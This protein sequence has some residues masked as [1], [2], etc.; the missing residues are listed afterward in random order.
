MY[1]C[2][3]GT[4]SFVDYGDRKQA[5]EAMSAYANPDIELLVNETKSNIIVLAML[6]S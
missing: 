4:N 5:E 6:K 1:I 3:D 2:Y